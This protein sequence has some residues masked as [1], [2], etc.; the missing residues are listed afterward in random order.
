M[1]HFF[2]F[3]ITLY[4]KYISP[5]KGFKCAYACYHRSLSCSA[6]VKNIIAEHGVIAGWPMIKQQFANCHLA[7]QYLETEREKK[8]RE[9]R[10]RSRRRNRPPQRECLSKK[11]KCDCALE[12]GDCVPDLPCNSIIFNVNKKSKQPSTPT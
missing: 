8:E 4:Q 2:I 7:Y 12:L 5:H 6:M 9:R 1:R 11:D 10:E 3:L